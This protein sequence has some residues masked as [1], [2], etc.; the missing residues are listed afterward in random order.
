MMKR[1][2]A[3]SIIL[4]I[5]MLI[6]VACDEL[7]DVSD[8]MRTTTWGEEGMEW[9]TL[10]RYESETGLIGYVD[11]DGKII[12]EPQFYWGHD[13]SEGLAFVKGV[14]GREDATGFIDVEGNL[15]IPLPTALEARRFSEGF[16]AVSVREWERPNPLIDGTS[17][18]FIF[19]NRAG[20]DVFGQ[21]F[22]TTRA[23]ENG[24][25]RI[26]LLNGNERYIDRTGNIVRSRP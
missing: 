12:I 8:D 15:V 6:T 16:A 9:E 23:F 17:G 25:A 10:Y 11:T 7:G 3:M 14:P 4:L 19:I 26:T 13:F 20:Q 5:V 21:E 1:T 2:I 22:L 24:Y 18:P